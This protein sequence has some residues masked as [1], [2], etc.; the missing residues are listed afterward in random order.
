MYAMAALL[1]SAAV[2]FFLRKNWIAFSIL[3]TALVFTDYVP[4]FLIPVFWLWGIFKKQN[5]GWWKKFILSHVPLFFL[6]ILWVPVFITQSQGGKWLLETLPEWSRVAGGATLKQA[7]LVWSKFTLGRISFPN[8]LI[9]YPLTLLASI[10]FLVAFFPVIVDRKKV[11]LLW[12]W[13]VVPLLVGFIVSIWVPAF[14]Y[15]RF[16]YVVPAFYLLVSWGITRFPKR[17]AFVLGLAIVFLNLIGWG[18]YVVDPTQ[19]RERWREAVSFVEDKAKENEIVV[20]SFTEPFAPYQWYTKGKVVA[21]G[22]TDSISANEKE[23]YRIA[24]GTISNVE[25]V[26]YFEYLWQLHDPER[27]VEKTIIETGFI[28][29]SAFD[30]PGVGIIRYYRRI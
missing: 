8:K 16:L 27:V 30:F 11:P 19:Q 22:V 7:G 3:L 23:T 14:I 9:Q 26:Y 10:P 18:I 1:A 20:F 13:F 21:R 4:I 12:F 2:F 15:F 28:Q 5:L 29:A 24:S 25:G 17:I 6:G